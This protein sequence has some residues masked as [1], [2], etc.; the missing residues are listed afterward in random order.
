MEYPTGH[1]HIG[2]LIQDQLKKDQRSVG[3]LSRQI[4]CSRNHVYKLFKRPSL[5]GEL[6][7]RISIVMQFN[8]FQYYTTEFLQSLKERTGEE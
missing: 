3:W 5:D 6:L 1:L 7:L 2:Q 4:P 8:F